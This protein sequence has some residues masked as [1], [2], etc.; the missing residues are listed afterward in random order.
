LNP[1]RRHLPERALIPLGGTRAA[2]ALGGTAMSKT[3]RAD[4]VSDRVCLTCGNHKQV[5]F[6]SQGQLGKPRAADGADLTLARSIS[7]K[8][9]KYLTQGHSAAGPQPEREHAK[10]RRGIMNREIRRTREKRKGKDGFNRKEHREHKEK[11][12][13][14]NR[15]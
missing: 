13:S 10:L 11:T 12:G 4:P 14:L 6:A 5:L 7:A 3:E 9:G 2:V 8:T 1:E 15:R